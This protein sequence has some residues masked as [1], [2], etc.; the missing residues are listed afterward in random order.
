[1]LQKTFCHVQGIGTK[2]ERH[3]WEQGADCWQTFLDDPTSFKVPRPRLVTMLDTVSRSPE[4]LKRGD[5]RFFNERLPSR[6]H[7]RA[8]DA[9]P[10][11]VAYLDIETDGGTEFENVT[12]IGLYDGHALQQFVRGENLLRF[13][14][15]LAD[16]AV[17]VTFYGGGFDLP[18]LKRAFPKLPFD[19]L[20]VDLC[21]TLRRLGYRG[22]LKSIEGQLGMSRSPETTG[23]NGW[24]AVRLWREWRRGREASLRTLLAYNAEDVL[25]MV[26][27]AALA[28]RELAARLTE[29]EKTVQ[30]VRVPSAA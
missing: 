9:F 24:D 28:A 8:L 5:Y 25:N 17:L 1:M 14:E 22:G 18:V 7:W 12:V 21:P 16:I 29:P 20:H 6:E 4:A 15:A 19:Q 26:P 11:R 30:E 2:T 3:L 23:L 27:L 13:P 10:G